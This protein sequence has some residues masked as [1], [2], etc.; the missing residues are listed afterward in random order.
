M[1]GPKAA[2]AATDA[3]NTYVVKIHNEHDKMRFFDTFLPKAPHRE[4]EQ[5][6]SQVARDPLQ[7][8]G[9]CLHQENWDPV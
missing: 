3:D 2:A 4:N 9:V 6:E 5:N 8:Q 7:G 1:Q